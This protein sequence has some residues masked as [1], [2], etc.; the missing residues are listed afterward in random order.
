MDTLRSGMERLSSGLASTALNIGSTVT[1]PV[2]FVSS[3][4]SNT[5]VISAI[6]AEAFQKSGDHVFQYLSL[7]EALNVSAC[8]RFTSSV[9]ISQA[10]AQPFLAKSK[11][12]HIGRIAI[13][14]SAA[15]MTLGNFRRVLFRIIKCSEGTLCID[16]TMG[17]VILDLGSA[18]KDKKAFVDANAVILV[19]SSEGQENSE[20]ILK[21]LEVSSYDEYDDFNPRHPSPRDML[22][23]HRRG[24]SYFNS[25]IESIAKDALLDVLD[26]S[27]IDS[28]T[29][30]GKPKSTGRTSRVQSKLGITLLMS[31]QATFDAHAS[32]DEE[33]DSK[34]E[35]QYF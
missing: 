34:P 20:P 15:P 30:A 1:T 7:K 22:K 33:D 25:D 18:Y 32:S 4:F 29:E 19:Q 17:R 13:K 2:A 10:T 9:N 3:F 8:S 21:Y 27:T 16:Y 24:D 14:I 5:N 26:L 28:Q 11:I 6:T 31:E 35:P 23:T 12:S